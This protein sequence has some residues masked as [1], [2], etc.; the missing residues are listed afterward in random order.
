[1]D[2]DQIRNEW[3]NIPDNDD[4]KLNLMKAEFA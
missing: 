2:N 3:N 1:M 4:R